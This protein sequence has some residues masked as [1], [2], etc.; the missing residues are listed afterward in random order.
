MSDQLIELLVGA[1]APGVYRSSSRLGADAIAERAERSG[2]RC[3]YLDGQRIATKDDFLQ[4]CA[5]AMCFPTYFGHNW[6]ALEDSLRDLAWAPAERG[7]LL[8]YDH[9]KRFAVTQ[10]G[11]FSVALDILQ[12]AVKAWQDTPTPMA[13]L[14]RGVGRSAVAALPK[15]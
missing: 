1:R 4:A 3:S 14:L 15:L 5:T 8:L 6:D 7:H 13:V 10:P 2:W 11:E 9:A 12:I